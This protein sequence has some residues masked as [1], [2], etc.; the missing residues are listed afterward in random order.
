MY[1]Y[2]YIYIYMYNIFGE[3]PRHRP[4]LAPRRGRGGAEPPGGAIVGYSLYCIIVYCR[5]V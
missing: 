1:I 3:G 4:H 5:T 2:I